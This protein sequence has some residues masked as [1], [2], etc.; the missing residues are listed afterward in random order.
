MDRWEA[1]YH[2]KEFGH[3]TMFWEYQGLG[4]NTYNQY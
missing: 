2:L 3:L 1:D 4:Q